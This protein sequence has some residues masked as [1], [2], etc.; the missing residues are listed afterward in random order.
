VREPA[1]VF[2]DSQQPSAP[3]APPAESSSD[4]AREPEVRQ[5]DTTPAE[6]TEEQSDRPR[7][8]GWWAKRMFGG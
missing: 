2:A 4:A 5:P 6:S 8:T 7:R 3:P 1:P